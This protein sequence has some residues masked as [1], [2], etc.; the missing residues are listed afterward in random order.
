MTASIAVCVA[1]QFTSLA[2]LTF[3]DIGF[4][5]P[6]R[7]GL[8]FNHGLFFTV[9]YF[10]SLLAGF[11]IAIKKRSW[12]IAVLQIAIPV[13]IVAWEFRP[14]PHYRASDYQHLVG[15]SEDEVE[16]TLSPRRAVYGSEGNRE[17]TRDFASYRGMTVYYDENGL[18]TSVEEND[19]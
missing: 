6:G 3:G 10:V 8:S 4:D 9:S 11:V 1:L 5:H 19:R 18:V 2:V 7:F 17:F 14:I 15:K 16:S 13:L 12:K